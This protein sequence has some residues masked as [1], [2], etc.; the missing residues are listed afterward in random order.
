M[1]ERKGGRGIRTP[2]VP[3]PNRDRQLQRRGSE[4]L[5][6]HIVRGVVDEL[7]DRS[8]R[9]SH[10]GRGFHYQDAVA[11]GLAVRAWCGELQLRRLVPEG[12]EDVSLELEGGWLHVQAK[13]RREHRGQFALA[14]LRPAWRHL[15]ERLVL[16]RTAHAALVLERP[17]PGV[18]AGLDHT[19]AL[20][21]SSELKK[22]VEDA[23]ADLE[24]EDFLSR[25]HVLVMSSPED[26][27][28]QLLAERLGIPSASCVAHQAV[29][30]GKLAR[31]ADENGE[32][33]A[34]NAAEATVGEIARWLEDVNE[35]IDPSALDEAVR[36][37]VAE[38]VDFATAIDDDRFFSGVD[39]VAGHVVAGLPVERPEVDQ[40]LAGLKDRRHALAIGPSGAGKSA[41][42]WLTAHA[43]RHHIRWYR[44]RRLRDDDVPSLVRLVKGL[45]PTGAQIG[46]VVDDLGRDDRAGCDHLVEELRNHPTA[47][48]LGA[49]RDE[50]L[51]VIRTAYDA[52][53]VRPTLAP[54]LAERIW[55]ELRESGGTS[56]PE[57]R[58]AYED[59]AGLLLEYGHLLTEGT[60]LEA[61]IAAQVNRRVRERRALELDVLGLVSTADS[62]GA[63]IDATRLTEA[64]AADVADMKGA[65]SRL[66]DEHLISEHEGALGGLHELRSRYLMET[67]HS[68]PPPVL[69]DT[70]TRVIDLVAGPALQPFVIR[71]LLEEAVADDVA[72][73][74]IAARLERKP[75]PQV[76]AAALQ[77]LRWVGFRRMTADWHD[78]FTAENV[79]VAH[80][81][82]VATFA[83]RGG[84][85]DILPEPI[86]RAISRLRAPEAIDL[87][88][89]LL[90]KI[91]L[92]VS[93][94][95][96]SAAD[97]HSAAT[98]LAA[99]GEV[100]MELPIDTPE[101]ARIVDV[102]PISDVRL[103]LEA[104]YA[105]TPELAIQVANDM[106]GPSVLLQRL[107]HEQPWVRN[108][109]LGTDNEGHPTAEAEYAYVAD[110]SQ[111]D[112]HDEVVELARYLAALAPEA[113]LVACRAIDAAG[114][115]AGFGG[116]PLADK[117]IPRGNLPSQVEVA[118]NRARIRA[119]IAA[120][121]APTETAHHL[122]VRELIIR[123]ARVV[124]QAVDAW[125]RGKQPSQ[126]LNQQIGSL[127]DAA[128]ALIPAPIAIETVRPLEEGDLQPD[129]PASF[130]GIMIA[131]SL[132]PRL[133]QGENVSPVIP[134]IVKHVDELR[135]PE[136]WRL[137][138][139]PPLSELSGLRENLLDLRA[140][141]AEHVH[142]VALRASGRNRL[143]IAA[144]I[145]RDRTA[146]RMQA[147][148]DQ[149]EHTLA[150]NGL[151][152]RVVRCEREADLDRWPN[153][154][155][156]VLVEVSTIYDWHR[157]LEALANIC[158]PPLKDRAGFLMA[159]I[160]NGHIVASGGVH[161]INDIFPGDESIRDW[162]NL[163]LPLL[164]EQ[165]GDTARQ[166]L[167]GL[168]EASG[169]IASV[170]R[171]EMHP[172]EVAAL[173]SAITRARS[174]L[175][176][177]EQLADS[178]D[179]Q[180]LTEV[181]DT[182]QA[183]SQRVDDEATALMRHEP[184]EQTIAA[185]VLARMTGRSDDVSNAQIGIAVACIEWDVE[186]ENA[187][188]RIEQALSET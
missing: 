27:A 160:R 153:D 56:W 141:L 154:D 104:A 76:L 135:D 65:L 29:L 156:L 22:A 69:A 181:R 7:W 113:T 105:V 23:V 11:T 166:G 131:N 45:V 163:P 172:E 14:E 77:A 183:M 46:F 108:A 146:T 106:G 98:V 102:A 138:D 157:N 8:R 85:H 178:H 64:L 82:T 68:V 121:A 31:L 43:S 97:V 60:R 162:P 150:G 38:L 116:I 81:A 89:E 10:A 12:L 111:S 94:A 124:R 151:R 186:P 88:K 123:S 80:V 2:A 112:I 169:I 127:A 20:A 173:E 118:W 107:E 93:T 143:N 133:F 4:P 87:R 137:L 114:N 115:T 35:A 170:R 125:V 41:L 44:V 78:V 167:A 53:Q 63:D 83:I 48:V 101:L 57:W 171:D 179:S 21:S 100:N 159:P 96:A 147:I 61:T 42:I 51:F 58:E 122:A 67:I 144:N 95:L 90:T 148:A 34:D 62:F 152:A 91:A 180:L 25:T 9:G 37:G 185:S 75:D 136:Y 149:L 99:L 17:L 1:A 28:V 165:L 92:Q 119:G 32:R 168:N 47:Y 71:L 161:V 142:D 155:F 164:D 126:Q 120:V 55:R 132:L 117:R 72:I 52:A 16:D 103:L 176:E 84:E 140:V 73:E 184:A 110:S 79:G 59:S 50:D 134:G 139:E 33:T 66:I 74:A 30:C 86:K 145:A 24:V 182:L 174:S 188:A 19:L 13:S 36:G 49:C 128:N 175:H 130:M 129:N 177:I 70:V 3:R 40:L 15:A 54:E 18:E 6:T 39:V 158:K 26:A 187:W 5:H 109:R